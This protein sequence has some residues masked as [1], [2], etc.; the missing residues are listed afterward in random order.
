VL[1][2]VVPG[3][4]LEYYLDLACGQVRRYGKAEPRV[5]RAQLRTLHSTG[6]FCRDDNGRRLVVDQ[7]K[8]VMTDAENAIVQPADLVVVR[9][10]ADRVLRDLTARG[11]SV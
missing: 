9:E 3:R 5:V 2:V 7:V 4:D 10:H 1:R 11:L 6:Q 8:L